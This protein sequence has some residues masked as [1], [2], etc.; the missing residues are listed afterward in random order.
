MDYPEEIF[1]ADEAFSAPEAVEEAQPFVPVDYTVSGEVMRIV[2]S[3]PEDGYSVI[4]L[5]DHEKHELTL[6]GVMPNVMEGQ[7]IEAVG[8]WEMH[9]EH[10]RQFRV[11]SFRSL[12]P[13]SK[14]GIRRFL[15][16][17]VLPGIGE[18]YANRIVEHFGEDT[19]RILDGFSERL[20]EVPGIGKKRIAEIRDAWKKTTAERET[21]IFLQG[22]GL[23]GNLCTKIIAKYGNGAIELFLSEL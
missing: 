10:G 14:E 13:S 19:I 12:L 15:A 16:S 4:R 1:E 20:K 6:V 18:T 7:E 2:Y 23:T 21:R 9:R 22:T 8:R 11:S 17:G 5:R 3:K